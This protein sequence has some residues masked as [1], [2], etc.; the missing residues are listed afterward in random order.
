[1]FLSEVIDISRSFSKSFCPPTLAVSG[2]SNGDGKMPIF[3][4]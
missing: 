2:G 3:L 4:T 1:M